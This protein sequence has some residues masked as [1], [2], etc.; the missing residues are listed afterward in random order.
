M[1]KQKFCFERVISGQL[2]H[3]NGNQSARRTQW[4][5]SH[6]HATVAKADPSPKIYAFSFILNP[7]F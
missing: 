1:G 4:L 5:K 7:L 6:P 3:N 2:D